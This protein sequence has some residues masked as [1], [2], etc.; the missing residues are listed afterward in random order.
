MPVQV[1]GLA[2]GAKWI[3]TSVDHACAV[4]AAG[5]V[6]CWGYNGDGQ[7]GTGAKGDPSAVPVDVPGLTGIARVVAGESH[8]CVLTTGG[9]VKCWGK[10]DA[11]QLGNGS[12]DPESLSPVDVTGLGSG[13]TAIAAGRTHTCAI[14]GGAAK[15]WGSNLYGEQGIGTA[16]NGV[17]TPGVVTGFA[18]G[19]AAISAGDS[20]TCLVTT[21]GAAHCFGKN[22]S[23]QLGNA[24]GGTG[25]EEHSPVAVSTL[26]T[27]TTSIAAGWGFACA[28]VG[29]GVKCWGSNFDLVIGNGETPS[30]ETNVPVA[31]STL[32]TGVA[33]VAASVHRACAITTAGALRCWGTS[34]LGNDATKAVGD[35]SSAIPVAVVG[36][37]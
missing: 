1:K 6:Q 17:R 22:D 15:C 37:P 12:T 8:T 29:G 4:T 18:S 31:V 33:S 35:Q 23:G 16:G 36:L 34:A 11:G 14:A 10:N 9:G 20:T 2:T 5:G 30:F 32:A 3:G 27:Q 21:G 13:V 24:K 28:L 7:L 26:T 19:V 25:E